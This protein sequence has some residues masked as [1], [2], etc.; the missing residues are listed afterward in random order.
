MLPEMQG[1]SY[2]HKNAADEDEQACIHLFFIHFSSYT[3]TFSVVLLL[4]DR[5][6]R[7][8]GTLG[9]HEESLGTAEFQEH[10]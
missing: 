5:S 10:I 6:Y 1:N 4:H 2:S 7:V 3:I 8:T 9:I